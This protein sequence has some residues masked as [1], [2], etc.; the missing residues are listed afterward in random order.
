VRDKRSR[1]FF[2]NV[3][4]GYFEHFINSMGATSNHGVQN[5]MGYTFVDHGIRWTK[6]KPTSI[7]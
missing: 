4:Q 5:A 2:V 3:K 1:V 7:A 6:Y